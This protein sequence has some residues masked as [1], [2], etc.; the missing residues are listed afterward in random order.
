MVCHWI[1]RIMQHLILIKDNAEVCV[2]QISQNK[3]VGTKSKHIEREQHKM[4]ATGLPSLLHD[5]RHS[6][7]NLGI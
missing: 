4:Y 3:L 1:V 6:D 7:R 2:D 5:T